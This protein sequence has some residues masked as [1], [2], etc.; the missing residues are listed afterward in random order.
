MCVCI[1]PCR[2][3]EQKRNNI[4]SK[5]VHLMK[6]QEIRLSEDIHACSFQDASFKSAIR[7]VSVFACA[8]FFVIHCKVN[9]SEPRVQNK[10][11]P[12]GIK[13]V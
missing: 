11:C 6:A 4:D 3:H 12:T 10:S 13:K 2:L 8:D 7:V 9:T 5:N 1:F